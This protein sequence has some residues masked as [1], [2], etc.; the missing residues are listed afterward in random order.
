MIDWD[1]GEFLGREAL[2]CQRKT[3]PERKLAALLLD[4]DLVVFGGEAVYNDDEVIAQTTSGNFAYS[5]GQPIALAY[6]PSA[7]ARSGIELKVQSFG[8]TCTA[9]VVM[10]TPFD[11]KRDKILC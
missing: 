3:G 1:K 11:S 10:G 8:K 6:L 4:D 2:V 9:K 5:L 7:L